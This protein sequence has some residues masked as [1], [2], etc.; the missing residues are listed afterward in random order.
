MKRGEQGWLPHSCMRHCVHYETLSQMSEYSMFRNWTTKSII[1][2][3]HGISSV[4]NADTHTRKTSF[5]TSHIYEKLIITLVIIC[6]NW[7][8]IIIT[9]M[10]YPLWV[11]PFTEGLWKNSSG[12]SVL[13]AYE[14]LFSNNLSTPR[15][16][17]SNKNSTGAKLPIAVFL[18]TFWI[19]T[20]DTAIKDADISSLATFPPVYLMF[21]GIYSHCMGD[22]LKLMEAILCSHLHTFIFVFNTL[23]VFI[24]SL[25]ADCE[26]FGDSN[27]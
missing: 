16:R 4:I 23:G 24:S 25:R 9:N 1:L 3:S 10:C 7:M 19:Y 20:C 11:M 27:S 5:E 22:M 26:P 21:W 18:Y 12:L 2:G 15:Q 14:T 13:P 17:F 8:W 6:L